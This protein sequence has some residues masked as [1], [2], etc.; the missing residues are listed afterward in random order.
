MLSSLL[1][2]QT[3][4]Q[5]SATRPGLLSGVKKDTETTALNLN[6]HL[7]AQHVMLKWPTDVMALTCRQFHSSHKSLNMI[8]MEGKASIL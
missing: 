7:C 1:S 2:P 4:G 6:L 8:H 3:T 5:S